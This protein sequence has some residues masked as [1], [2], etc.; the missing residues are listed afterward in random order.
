LAKN[1]CVFY[2]ARPLQCW[3]NIKR[4]DDIRST[5]V[6]I[7]GGKLATPIMLKNHLPADLD[8]AGLSLNQYLARLCSE[9]TT[10]IN[11]P[12]YAKVI[13][14]LAHRRS[15][16]AIAEELQTIA[17][18]SPVDFSPDMLAQQMIERLDEI[19]VA[20]TEGPASW[21]LIARW[22]LRLILAGGAPR[23]AL[24]RKASAADIS[25]SETVSQY[26]TGGTNSNETL[27]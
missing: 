24:V 7:G 12:D 9:A 19:V 20:R 22:P 4:Y 17:A 18:A 10:V 2:S 16:M 13:R 11:A 23:D 15:M 26:V 27:A 1:V 25:L 8:I 21:R 6:D 3:K 14:D 5:T